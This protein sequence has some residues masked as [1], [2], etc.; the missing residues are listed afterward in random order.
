MLTP[1]VTQASDPKII[2]DQSMKSV[3][4]KQRMEKK[5]VNNAS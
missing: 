1:N 5:N 4:L 2:G 3:K